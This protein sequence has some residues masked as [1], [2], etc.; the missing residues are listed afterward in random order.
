ML[1]VKTTWG[2]HPV[3]MLT[4]IS[5]MSWLLILV[6]AY[7]SVWVYT[8]TFIDTLSQ[9]W[10]FWLP[11]LFRD[12]DFCAQW[13]SQEKG[14]CS[15]QVVLRVCPGGGGLDEIDT[16]ISHCHV[17]SDIDVVRPTSVDQVIHASLKMCGI[18]WI[19]KQLWIKTILSVVQLA[20]LCQ[21]SPAGRSFPGKEGYCGEI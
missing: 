4:Q 15:L 18:F 8:D 11:V 2:K 12:E 17:K 7:L 1:Q 5:I 20:R 14:F 9:G 3:I 16:C 13:L 6:V 21:C 19:T 10:S